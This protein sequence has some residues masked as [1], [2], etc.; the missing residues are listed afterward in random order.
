[1]PLIRLG[2]RIPFGERAWCEEQKWTGWI[3]APRGHAE[4][5][6]ALLGI[7]S[8]DIGLLWDAL[9]EAAIAVP[10]TGI[11]P[12]LDGTVICE[13]VFEL[14]HHGRIALV[15][16]PGMWRATTRLLDR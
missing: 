2:Q 5:W 10:V 6:K 1:V 4:D 16:P 7:Q 11:R 8:E 13:I 15:S 9:H 3:F 14:E 12:R